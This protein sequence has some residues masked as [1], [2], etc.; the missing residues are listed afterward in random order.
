[1][2]AAATG[3]S[4]PEP[5]CVLDQALKQPE[6]SDRTDAATKRVQDL[7]GTSGLNMLGGLLASI[8]AD[9]IHR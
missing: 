8:R 4:F 6:A 3:T 9:H 2:L 7:G 5:L 1:M